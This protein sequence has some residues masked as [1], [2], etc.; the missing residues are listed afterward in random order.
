MRFAL[1][2][3]LLVSGFTAA[4]QP[5][6][7]ISGY[8]RDSLSGE[9]LIGATVSI[10]GKNLVVQSNQYGFYSITVPQS[11]YSVIITFAGYQPTVNEVNLNA[12]TVINFS[13]L[14]RSVLQEVIVS[15]RRRDGNV[16]NA[17]MGKIDLS[18]AQV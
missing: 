4:G 12:D 14:Q 16:T 15:S 17:Q 10:N 7:T 8:V 1:V 13:L 18:M 5:K 11:H 2:F 3:I 6:F 9:N